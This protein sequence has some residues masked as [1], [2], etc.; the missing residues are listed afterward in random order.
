MTWLARLLADAREA[1]IDVLAVQ[2]LVIFSA[3]GLLLSLVAGL[4]FG[5]DLAP[6][7]F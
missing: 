1:E 4:S 7:L 5:V 6:S 2:T 3:L